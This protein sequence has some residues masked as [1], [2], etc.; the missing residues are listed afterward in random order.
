[1]KSII[2]VAI[3][4]LLFAFTT[5]GA[6]AGSIDTSLSRGLAAGGTMTTNIQYGSGG[7]GGGGRYCE[8]LRRACEYK[9]ARGETGEGNCRRYRSECGGRGSYCERLRRACE[10]KDVRGETGQGNCREY[11]RQ[12]R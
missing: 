11:R 8:R 2:A 4:G 12:C 6:S 1:M 10:Y 9:D 5:I 7:Y 3:T